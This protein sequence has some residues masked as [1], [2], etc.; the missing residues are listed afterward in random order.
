MIHVITNQPTYDE[1][2]EKSWPERA[3]KSHEMVQNRYDFNARTA[4]RV[5]LECGHSCVLTGEA[6]FEEGTSIRCKLCADQL[7]QMR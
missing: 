3:I 6:I 4:I 7:N 1:S 5:I 2:E